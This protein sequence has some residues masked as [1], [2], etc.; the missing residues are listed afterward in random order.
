MLIFPN[1]FETAKD[2]ICLSNPRL[3]LN[4]TVTI[5]WYVAAQITKL[6][7]QFYG[8][9]NFNIRVIVPSLGEKPHSGPASA[10]TPSY[11]PK[12]VKIIFPLQW[13][14]W[15]LG[16]NVC[17]YLCHRSKLGWETGNKTTA[18]D[19]KVYGCEWFL[20]SWTPIATIDRYIY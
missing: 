20:M 4:V 11:R 17:A 5:L 13:K 2:A 16:I 3:A 15:H 8:W 19:A 18:I 9:L 1:F 7:Y 12:N 14:L 6:M 10:G